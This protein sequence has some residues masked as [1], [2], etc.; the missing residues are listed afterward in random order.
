MTQ[1]LQEE[2][3]KCNVK[4]GYCPSCHSSESGSL[5]TCTG[6]KSLRIDLFFD[7]HIYKSYLYIDQIKSTQVDSRSPNNHDLLLPMRLLLHLQYRHMDPRSP[8]VPLFRQQ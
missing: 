3:S 6:R 1:G 7:F 4:N 8:M 2:T 5:P